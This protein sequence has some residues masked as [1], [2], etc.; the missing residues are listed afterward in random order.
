MTAPQKG[1][2]IRPP[3]GFL[4]WLEAN[5]LPFP[6]IAAETVGRL[7]E[8]DEDC[9]ATD[10]RA[11]TRIDSMVDL[12]LLQDEWSEEGYLAPDYTGLSLSGTGLQDRRFTM[13]YVDPSHNLALS[14]PWGCAYGSPEGERRALISAYRLL[15]AASME[16]TEGDLLEAVVTDES[17]VWRRTGSFGEEL[18]TDVDSLLISLESAAT[19]GLDPFTLNWIPA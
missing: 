10:S 2:G 14:M 19:G 11:L 6:P 5:K 13:V 8:F 15:T 16:L 12:G 7:D 1:D 3:E 17:V 4:E 18:G 9:F